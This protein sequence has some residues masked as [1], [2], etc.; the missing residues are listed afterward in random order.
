MTIGDGLSILLDIPIEL[1]YIYL[2]G[3]YLLLVLFYAF[4]LFVKS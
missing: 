2:S 1:G 4:F 3:L